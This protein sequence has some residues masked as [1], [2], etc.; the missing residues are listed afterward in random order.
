[1]DTGVIIAIVIG[2]LLLIALFVLLGKKGRE[3]KM[4]TRRD[5]SRE[6]RREAEVKDARADR[7]GAEA[8]E[9][10]AK[11]RREEAI[12]REQSAEAEKHKREAHEHHAKAH[13]I[14][15]DAK[16]EYRPEEGRT[17]G[18]TTAGTGSET[19]SGS[20][21]Q[22]VQH[23]ERTETTDEEHERRFAR[24]EQGEVVAD[25]EVH[26]TRRDR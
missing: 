23:Y 26:Q 7:V 24:N 14:D 4:E 16:G 15:P 6:I 10:A 19:G 1:M 21:D 25:E 17:T 9:R 18:A 22:G 11:A 13:E 3:R 2:V 12:A 20:D 8:E 5:E